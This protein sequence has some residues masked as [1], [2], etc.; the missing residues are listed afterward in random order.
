MELRRGLRNRSEREQVLPLL[1]GCHFLEQPPGL[2]E[3]AGELGNLL[4]QR[5]TT[6]KSMDLLI[7]T[8]ALSHDVAVLAN[9][10]DFQVIRRAGVPLRL[11]VD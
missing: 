2:W 11:M 1:R 4:G 10:A 6:I 9:D 7:A 3:E 5:G 8:H